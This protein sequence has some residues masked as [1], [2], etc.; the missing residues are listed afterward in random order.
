MIFLFRAVPYLLSHVMLLPCHDHLVCLI[1]MLLQCSGGIVDH[2]LTNNIVAPLNIVMLSTCSISDTTSP[3][4]FRRYTYLLFWVLAMTV[5]CRYSSFF[6]LSLLAIE[7]IRCIIL[8]HV[9]LHLFKLRNPS[10]RFTLMCG[11]FLFM[12]FYSFAYAMF[13]HYNNYNL[14]ILWIINHL[15]NAYEGCWEHCTLLLEPHLNLLAIT[16]M[17]CY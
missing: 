15:P 14:R 13:M 1:S 7:C 9:I 17:P 6:L 4:I 8:C 11:Q 5:A 16:F 2:P 10:S 3:P 12:L